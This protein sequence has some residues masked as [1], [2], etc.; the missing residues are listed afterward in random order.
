MALGLVF[1]AGLSIWERQ[2]PSG[3]A[4]RMNYYW[5]VFLTAETGFF[6]LVFLL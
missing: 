1:A 2:S 4:K 6:R 5:N 3:W